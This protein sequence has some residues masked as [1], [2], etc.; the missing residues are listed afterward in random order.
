MVDTYKSKSM[1]KTSF[2]GFFES[3]RQSAP[4]AAA[5][6]KGIMMSHSSI[7]KQNG[8]YSNK[9]R[10]SRTKTTLAEPTATRNAQLEVKPRVLESRISQNSEFFNLSD[11]FK[12]IFSNDRKDKKMII[13][14]AGYGGH[15]RGDRSQNFFGKSFRESSLQSKKL[16]RHLRC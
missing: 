5:T 16:E 9:Y 8:L 1:N 14:I 13:P 11:G 3:Q 7:I 10:T 4:S 2:G 6:M 12:N 15:R